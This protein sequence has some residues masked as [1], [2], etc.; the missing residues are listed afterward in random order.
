MVVELRAV[1]LLTAKHFRESMAWRIDQDSLIKWYFAHGSILPPLA[2]VSNGVCFSQ[3]SNNCPG[4]G[5]ATLEPINSSGP[6]SAR[7]RTAARMAAKFKRAE[8]RAQGDR[9]RRRPSE[10]PQPRLR[11]DRIGHSGLAFAAGFGANTTFC[12]PRFWVAPS[13][14]LSF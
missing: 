9:R 10:A 2:R 4:S 6:P 3:R 13:P 11:Y 7:A 8:S 5:G 1:L 12:P 14:T